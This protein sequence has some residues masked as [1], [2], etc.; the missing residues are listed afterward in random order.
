MNGNAI[1]ISAPAAAE[2]ASRILDGK[3]VYLMGGFIKRVRVP[4]AQVAACKAAGNDMEPCILVETSSVTLLC[5]EVKFH[6][7]TRLVQSVA[8]PCAVNGAILWLETEAPLTCFGRG[9]R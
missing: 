8:E 3:T 4:G 5:F 9:P 2:E 7:P 1:S 6:G